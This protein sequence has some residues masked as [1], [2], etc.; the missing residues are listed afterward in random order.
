MHDIEELEVEIAQ[1]EDENAAL[2]SQRNNWRRLAEDSIAVIR[3]R[4]NA[5]RQAI[6]KL[7]KTLTQ[8]DRF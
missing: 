2:L 8:L 4:E 1:L 6:G 3:N 5:T 7:L